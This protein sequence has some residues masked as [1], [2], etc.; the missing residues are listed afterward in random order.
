MMRT[1][2]E[3]SGVIIDPSGIALTNHHVIMGA[4]VSGWGGLADGQLYAWKLVGT[5]PGGDVAIIQMEGLDYFPSHRWAILKPSGSAIGLWRWEI[6]LFDRGPGSDKVTVSVSGIKRYQTGAR[7]EPVGLWK[8]HSSRQ[9]NESG[10]FGW[11]AVQFGQ[12]RD[13]NQ[14]AGVSDRGRVN[15]GLGYAISAIRSRILF[16]ICWQP[17]WLSMARWTRV[18]PTVVAKSSVPRSTALHQ[19]PLPGWILGMNYW[20]LKAPK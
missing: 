5:D 7:K 14:W 20:S 15:V 4:G 6:R 18:F 10:Q 2:R 9:L 8:L 17:S 13:R 3:G 11:S 19:W 12:S 1:A 16:P